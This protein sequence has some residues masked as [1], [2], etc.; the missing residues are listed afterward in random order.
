MTYK[1][2]IDWLRGLEVNI[3]EKHPTLADLEEG[4]WIASKPDQVLPPRAIR[5]V[6]EALGLDYDTKGPDLEE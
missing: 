2:L 3:V 1:E 6:F 5:H 4:Q